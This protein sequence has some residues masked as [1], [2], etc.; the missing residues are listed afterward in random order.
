MS[1]I[2]FQEVNIRCLSL[3]INHIKVHISN[4]IYWKKHLLGNNNMLKS[5]LVINV[6]YSKK[7]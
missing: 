2:V 4:L 6:L 5:K 7:R 3:V 1:I